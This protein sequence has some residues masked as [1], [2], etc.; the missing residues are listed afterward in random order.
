[1]GRWQIVHASDGGDLLRSYLAEGYEPFAVTETEQV[2][3]TIWLKKWA[4]LSDVPVK[5]LEELPV[6]DNPFGIRQPTMAGADV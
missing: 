5:A 2:R 4:V 6:L 1:M 3:A